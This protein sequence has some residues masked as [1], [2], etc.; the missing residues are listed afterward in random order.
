MYN[1]SDTYNSNW[2][3]D[4][5]VVLPKVKK[6]IEF[7]TDEKIYVSIDVL[8]EHK[9]DE[10]CWNPAKIWYKSISNAYDW[11]PESTVYQRTPWSSFHATGLSFSTNNIEYLY[12]NWRYNVEKY[13]P[14]APIIWT[15]NLSCD[16]VNDDFDAD[17][18]Q[19][20]PKA[21]PYYCDWSVW[22]PIWNCSK[23]WCNEWY[24]CS[25]DWY[26]K[27]D[28]I[29][30]EYNADTTCE[31]PLTKN[32]FE[33]EDV[34]KEKMEKELW[35][36]KEDYDWIYII[37]WN[38][39]SL[40][41]TEEHFMDYKCSHVATLIKAWSNLMMSENSLIKPQNYFIDCSHHENASH[42]F[43]FYQDIW[44]HDM[45]HEVLHRFWAADVYETWLALWYKSD[46]E[47]ALELDSKADESIMWNNHRS[48]MDEVSQ[49]HTSENNPCSESEL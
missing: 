2:K 49:K 26:C 41:D 32:I 15:W 10:L 43:W 5:W 35:F 33:K 6:W 39:W 24:K 14:N 3:N 34:I 13:I 40:K 30:E 37:Y 31:N 4:I 28:N 9:T 47:K 17:A 48:C 25:I 20:M 19:C 1:H 46:R 27:Q 12:Q 21:K 11:F 16:E 44:W 22:K 36:K 7:A 42:A 23:C 8:W 29:L 38:L 45:V 18:N